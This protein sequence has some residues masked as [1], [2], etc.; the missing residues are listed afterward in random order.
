MA[1]S[2]F[3]EPDKG[4]LVGKGEQRLRPLLEVN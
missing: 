2:R 1:E 4:L 3:K